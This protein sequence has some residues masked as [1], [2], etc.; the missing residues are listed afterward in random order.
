MPWEE[1]MP[2]LEGVSS[3]ADNAS[4]YPASIG[5]EIS[6]SESSLRTR[7]LSCWNCVIFLNGV[8]SGTRGR[9]YLH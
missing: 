3:K 6:G 8:E 5:L 2:L 7:A 1:D 4:S 9:I